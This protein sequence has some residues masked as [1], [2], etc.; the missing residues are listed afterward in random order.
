MNARN[1][2]HQLSITMG[3]TFSVDILHSSRV[4]FAVISDRNA[5][6][7]VQ[8]A[9]HAGDPEFF[10]PDVLVRELMQLR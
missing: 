9:G 7:A 1:G 2:L 5:L 10:V 6:L 3:Q 4:G 8:N